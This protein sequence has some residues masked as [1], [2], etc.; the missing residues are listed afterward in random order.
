M[1]ERC[2]RKK[3][4]IYYKRKR[5]QTKGFK[6]PVST[7]TVFCGVPAEHFRRTGLCPAF[8]GSFVNGLG[9]PGFGFDVPGISVAEC[10]CFQPYKDEISAFS[11]SW[12]QNFCIFALGVPVPRRS[13][14]AFPKNG[15][16]FGFQGFICERSRRAGFWV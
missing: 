11:V 6:R 5:A 12:W 13:G 1:Q 15:R 10:L 9:V 14:G 8:R 16:V 3:K 2:I 4:V 7:E